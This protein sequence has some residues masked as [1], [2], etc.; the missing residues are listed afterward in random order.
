M[1]S[2]MMTEAER[3]AVAPRTLVVRN[4]GFRLPTDCPTC[5]PVLL[6]TDSR[7]PDIVSLP[8]SPFDLFPRVGC[9]RW[10][11]G[12]GCCRRS[13]QPTFEGPKPSRGAE[14]RRRCGAAT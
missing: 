12:C 7:F 14:R 13:Y 9:V 11:D 8:A 1:A 4:P 3:K 2:T 6:F 5:L 10:S